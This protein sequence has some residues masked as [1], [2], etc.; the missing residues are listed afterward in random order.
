[1]QGGI[2]KPKPISMYCSAFATAPQV[3]ELD[4]DDDDNDDEDIVLSIDAFTEPRRRRRTSK[5]AR[6]CANT[7]P[8]QN[9]STVKNAA[10]GTK[11]N[12]CPVFDTYMG[13][14]SGA[15]LVVV[16]SHRD[17]TNLEAHNESAAASLCQARAVLSTRVNEGK[18]AAVL[19]RYAKEQSERGERN[20]CRRQEKQRQDSERL[21]KQAEEA[22]LKAARIAAPVQFKVRSGQKDQIK[23]RTRRSDRLR[24]RLAPFCKNFDL[25]P[26]F[27]CGPHPVFSVFLV[28]S[29][30]AVA[31]FALTIL[32]E[33]GLLEKYD[34]VM[35]N[36][37]TLTRL[38][39]N[40]FLQLL[41][42]LFITSCGVQF[43]ELLGDPGQTL[44]SETFQI[45]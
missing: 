9:D 29:G 4:V 37:S 12:N 2:P 31:V 34:I 17:K 32:V 1:M 25:N 8:S 42:F 21:R 16:E 10:H 39:I 6:T 41:T 14:E 40:L 5:R 22:R 15:K 27:L 28:C 11:Q 30:I 18:I 19:R 43:F 24:K 3:A 44:R 23:M 33:W 26:H 38:V 20:T 45:T 36:N 13:E 35:R 7:T